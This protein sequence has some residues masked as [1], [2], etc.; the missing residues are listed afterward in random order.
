[1]ILA[2]LAA[3]VGLADP[4][5]VVTTAPEG[6]EAPRPD[7]VAPVP[8]ELA[9]AIVG[10]GGAAIT[11]DDLT[12]AEQIDRWIAARPTD[13][14]PFADADTADAAPRRIH[15]EVGGA[16]GTNDF[17]AYGGSVQIPIGQTGWLGLSYSESR[18]APYSYSYSYGGY[19][20]YGWDGP[21]YGAPSRGRSY[22][23]SAEFSSDERRSTDR[24]REGDLADRLDR[25]QFR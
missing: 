21:G 15:G 25:Y 12:T 8:V 6:A 18:N 11:Q 5:G 13:A 9:P 23:L 16:I 7:E 17:R 2:V 14:R 3:V 22:S 10:A 4:D 20:A 1:M 19:G 24:R